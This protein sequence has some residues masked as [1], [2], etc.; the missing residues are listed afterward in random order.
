MRT[1]IT[2]NTDSFHA[3]GKLD[4]LKKNI[5]VKKDEPPEAAIMRC[6]VQQGIVTK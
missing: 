6:T 5:Q 3:L 2:P 1:R 4:H